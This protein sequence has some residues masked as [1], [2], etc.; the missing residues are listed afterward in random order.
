[1]SWLSSTTVRKIPSRNIRGI[2]FDDIKYDPLCVEEHWY[3]IMTSPEIFDIEF[4]TPADFLE[5]ELYHS[6]WTSWVFPTSSKQCVVKKEPMQPLS[7]LVNLEYNFDDTKWV[8]VVVDEEPFPPGTLVMHSGWHP[9]DFKGEK[10]FA[11]VVKRITENGWYILLD[12]NGELIISGDV[13]M[14]KVAEVPK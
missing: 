10:F 14:T 6:D 3:P 11:V 12:D 1:M 9:L 8:H 13:M 4:G 7:E 2:T 5:S